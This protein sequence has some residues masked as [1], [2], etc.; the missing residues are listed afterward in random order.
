MNIYLFFTG[1]GQGVAGKSMTYFCSHIPRGGFEVL[2]RELRRLG[3][4]GEKS[5]DN[6]QT[7]RS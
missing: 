2:A 6:Q 3:E 5:V 4:A 7:I 1:T